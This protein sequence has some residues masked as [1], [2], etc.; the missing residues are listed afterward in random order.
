MTLWEFP[1][2]YTTLDTKR[3]QRC[4]S[5]RKLIEIDTVVLAFPR[6]KDPDTDIELDI[7]GEGGEIPR[8]TKYMCE[9]CAD[10]FFSLEDL[11]FCGQPWEDQRELVKE[12][13]REYGPNR[14]INVNFP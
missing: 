13:A 10:L 11:K 5:C 2:D 14:Q 12:Y 3:R 6:Y 9:S 7:Y 8:A 1:G 4:C